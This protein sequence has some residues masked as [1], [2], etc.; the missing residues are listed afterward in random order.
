MLCKRSAE[1][2]VVLIRKTENGDAVTQ[3]SQ[4]HFDASE[5]RSCGEVGPASVNN[6]FVGR[7]GL[8]VQ[9]KSI[10]TALIV[11]VRLDHAIKS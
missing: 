8:S 6:V 1:G 3:T 10:L 7:L 2:T 11:R 9:T 4:H 5:Y